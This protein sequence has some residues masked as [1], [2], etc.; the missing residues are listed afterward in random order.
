[1]SL[2]RTILDIMK[3]VAFTLPKIVAFIQDIIMSR[4][5]ELKILID[6]GKDILDIKKAQADIRE[7]TILAVK[8]EFHGSDSLIPEPIIRI[9]YEWLILKLFGEA[10]GY[11]K[12]LGDAF[13]AGFISRDETLDAESQINQIKKV[14]PELFGIRD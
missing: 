5:G 7:D 2:I 6:E 4:Q 13:D 11:D 14:Y 9:L 1:M 8:E 12:K 10:K 3:M